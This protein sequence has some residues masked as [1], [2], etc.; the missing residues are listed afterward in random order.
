MVTIININTITIPSQLIIHAGKR[1]Y[2]LIS[3]ISSFKEAELEWLA[4]ELSD[5]LDL[6]LSKE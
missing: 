1:K 2:K 6:S 3:G 5:W 4:Y